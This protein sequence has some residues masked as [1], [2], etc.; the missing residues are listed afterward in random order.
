MKHPIQSEFE[1]CNL[2]DERLNAR[3]AAVV[4]ALADD[5]SLSFPVALGRG[6]ALEGC[7]RFLNNERVDA[8]AIIAPHIDATVRRIRGRKRVL[9]VHDTTVCQ[10]DGERPGL[11]A[12]QL[13]QKAHGFLCHAALAVSAD[14][15]REPLGVLDLETWQRDHAP[16][17]DRAL[18]RRDDEDR[19]SKRWLRQSVTVDKLIGDGVVLIHVEDREG[20]IYESFYKR[21]EAKMRFIVRA[22]T[23][24][25]VKVGDETQNVAAFMR[26]QERAF[27]REVTLSRRPGPA[28]KKGDSKRHTS[29][30]ARSG[31]VARLA[32][33]AAPVELRRPLADKTNDVPPSIRLNVVHVLE[34][35]APDDADPVEWLLFTTEP[36]STTEEIEDVIDNYRA[37]WVIEEYFKA[38]KT[39]CSYEARQLESY[40][41]LTKALGFFAVLAWRLLWMRFLAHH[42]PEAPATDYATASE[43]A[44][45]RARKVLKAPTVAGYLD[46]VAALGGHLKHNGPPG[47]QVL[48]RGARKLELLVEGW[49]LAR[50]DQ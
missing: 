20:D 36:I 23:T 16:K 34:V 10:F 41:A 30:R 45:L 9:I 18:R 44:V 17:V 24:R 11:A 3:L 22:Q 32:I 14:G 42:T 50:C 1:G 4:D 26:S 28:A 8:D 5:P 46:A 48:W 6:A 7:Y 35:G 40:D 39:G 12:I 21:I 37:R 13:D 2:G 33:A 27:E 38:L 49:E 31:R 15:R 29:N 47:W 19:E 25:V 43:L